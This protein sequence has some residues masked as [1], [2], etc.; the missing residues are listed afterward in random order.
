MPAAGIDSL[1]H[2]EFRFRMFFFPG[3][4]DGRSWNFYSGAA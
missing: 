1:A 4:R 3:E 2:D